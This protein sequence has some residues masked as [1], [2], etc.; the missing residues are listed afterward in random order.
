MPAGYVEINVNS[1]KNATFKN[2]VCWTQWSS[3][4]SGGHLTRLIFGYHINHIICDMT[5]STN[6]KYDEK[7]I[8]KK[9]K[10]Y[11]FSMKKSHLMHEKS[12]IHSVVN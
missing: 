8:S 10:K 11:W 1:I 7:N 5:L 2:K 9:K 3:R 12:N 4:N 6:F